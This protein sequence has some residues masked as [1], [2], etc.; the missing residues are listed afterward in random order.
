MRVLFI[1]QNFPGQ[2]KWLSKALEWLHHEVSVLVPE[3]NPQKDAANWH[4]YSIERHNTPNIHPWLIDFETQLARGQGVFKKLCQLRDQGYRPDLVIA[5][6]GWGEI[7]FLREVWPDVKIGAYAEYFYAH[8]GRD[9]NFDPEFQNLHADLA[10]R[11]KIKN[12]N[13]EM[14]FK[15]ADA[16]ISPTVFQA[17]SFPR[18]IREKITVCHDG[19]NTDLIKP[20]EDGLEIT[21]GNKI[22]LRKSDEIIT[23]VNRN[24]EPYRGFHVFMRA[25]PE[26][27]RRRPNARVLIIGGSGVSYGA[28]SAD[29]RS[30]KEIYVS[31]VKPRMPAQDWERVH[32]LGNVDYK[33]F[34]GVIAVSTVHV[35]LTYPFVLSWSLL[36]SLAMTCAVVASDTEPVQEVVTHGENGLLVNFF[37]QAQL[38]ESIIALLKDKALRNRLGRTG[39]ERIIEEY[40]LNRVC[41]PK[42]LKWIDGILN[43]KP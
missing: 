32:F 4:R 7:L 18:D 9:I 5:H 38:V 28:R 12:I 43:Q 42:Q 21:L 23:F 35:Y 16:A 13:S 31:E 29:G 2:F 19:V 26:L 33:A 25:L 36:E 34:L 6:P 8:T 1:H 14:S 15:I 30:W 41:I 24:L 20:Q 27:L 17:N 40:D 3:S 22:R 10:C 39:R 37:D 11:I